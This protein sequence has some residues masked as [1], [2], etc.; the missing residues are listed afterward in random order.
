MTAVVQHPNVSLHEQL[1]KVH[2]SHRTSGV[3][4]SY[5]KETIS[6]TEKQVSTPFTHAS[7][8]LTGSDESSRRHMSLPSVGGSITRQHT[9]SRSTTFY[10]TDSLKRSTIRAY[11]MVKCSS[12]SVSVDSDK[13]LVRVSVAAWTYTDRSREMGVSIF[14][15]RHQPN[16]SSP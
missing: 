4:S 15:G 3:Y 9:A 13:L 14:A 2:I 5:K 12:I 7:P 1:D 8:R 10:P 16:Q 6:E 11:G